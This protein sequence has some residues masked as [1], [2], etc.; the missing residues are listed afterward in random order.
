[1]QFEAVSLARI[2][3]ILLLDQQEMYFSS[4]VLNRHLSKTMP[5]VLGRIALQLFAV[6]AFSA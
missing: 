5:S 6:I 3:F 2:K 1:M 4:H